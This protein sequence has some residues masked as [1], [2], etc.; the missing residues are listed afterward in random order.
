MKGRGQV[1]TRLFSENKDL[2]PKGPNGGANLS[3]EQSASTSL[4]IQEIG[5]AS[6]ARELIFPETAHD[7]SARQSPQEGEEEICPEEQARLDEE[8]SLELARAL[9]AEEAMASYTAAYEVSM[10]YLRN[11]QNEFSQED[12]AALQA[13]VEEENNANEGDVAEDVADVSGMSYDMLLRLGDQM[14]DVKLE[15]WAMVAQQKIESLP[16]VTFNPESLD[17]KNSNDCDGKCLVC[18][19]NY[20]REESLRRLP[21]NHLFHAECVDQWLRSSDKCPFCR[22]SLNDE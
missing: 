4:D 17:D 22:T 7:E 13:A 11:H 3:I 19:E 6:E 20:E 1:N 8:A 9:Q 21:C 5:Q 16:L 2:D 15:R 10:D 14:G 18:Q 12:L